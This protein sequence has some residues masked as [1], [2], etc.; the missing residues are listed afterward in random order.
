MIPRPVHASPLPS[1]NSRWSSA[2]DRSSRLSLKSMTT[3]NRSSSDANTSTVGRPVCRTLQCRPSRGSVQSR[4]V[5]GYGLPLPRRWGGRAAN[6]SGSLGCGQRWGNLPLL[7]RHSHHRRANC[8][9]VLSTIGSTRGADPA[10]FALLGRFRSTLR[11][12][13]T[14]SPPTFAA[15]WD[16][17]GTQC[18][19]NREDGHL[20][21]M[22]V[23]VE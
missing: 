8:A 5:M 2:S 3:L 13:Q 9:R 19:L 7:T 15:P 21:T 6:N 16:I 23:G 4:R 1:S 10:N 11:R 12:F 18:A 14:V 17:I 22:G 20:R